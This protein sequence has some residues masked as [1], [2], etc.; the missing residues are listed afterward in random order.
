[1]FNI[2]P[3]CKKRLRRKQEHAI[4]KYGG[5]VYHFCCG[6]CKESFEQNP[7]KYIPDGGLESKNKNVWTKNTKH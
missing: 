4:L 3:V 2:D 7:L 6:A 1:M 5:S